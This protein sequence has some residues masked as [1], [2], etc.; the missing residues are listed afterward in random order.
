MKT[1]ESAPGDRMSG[2]RI[3]REAVS[4]SEEAAVCIFSLMIL[5]LQL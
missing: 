3:D 4:H 1:W 5:P 2:T